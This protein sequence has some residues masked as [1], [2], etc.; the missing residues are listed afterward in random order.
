MLLATP[1]LSTLNHGIKKV[2]QPIAESIL[3]QASWT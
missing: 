1:A 2:V 3:I